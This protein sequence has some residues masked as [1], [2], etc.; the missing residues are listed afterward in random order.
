MPNCNPQ[1]AWVYKKVFSANVS[2]F[3]EKIQIQLYCHI[4]FITLGIKFDKNRT[5]KKLHTKIYLKI[6]V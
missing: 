1:K 2:N 5:R 3:K 6:N 4:H